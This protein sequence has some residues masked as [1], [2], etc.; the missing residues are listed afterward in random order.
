MLRGP[1]QVPILDCR[2]RGSSV[3]E[4]HM[5][6]GVQCVMQSPPLAHSSKGSQRCYTSGLHP[7]KSPVR[8]SRRMCHR[9]GHRSCGRCAACGR[10]AGSA[11]VRGPPLHSRAPAHGQ[12]QASG[13]LPRGRWPAHIAAGR[14]LQALKGLLKQN[15]VAVT[16]TTACMCGRGVLPR[17]AS[18]PEP[19]VCGFCNQLGSAPR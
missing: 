17:A 9:C 18:R 11:A 15:S 1:R 19:N 3:A 14:L 13:W 2:C 12:C 5:T 10:C 16:R 8:R 4:V 7:Q 6:C